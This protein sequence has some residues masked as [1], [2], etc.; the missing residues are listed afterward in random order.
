MKRIKFISILLT[1]ALISSLSEL[2]AQ[3]AINTDGSAPD[4]SA[5][6][7]VKSTDKGILIPRVTSNS[8]V[9]SP[10]A[11]LLIYNTTDKAFYYYDGTSWKIISNKS[12]QWTDAGSDIYF[13]TGG[14]AIG[15]TTADASA[16][17][18]V[19][20][21]N[22]GILIPRVTS[23]SN[24]TSPV[25]GLLIYNTTDKAFYYYDGSAWNAISNKSSQWTTTGSDIYYNTGGIAVGGT[26]VNASAAID[27]QST[28]KGIL[29]PRMANTSGITSPATGLMIYNTTSSAFYY[30]D[31]SAWKMINNQWTTSGS[32]I[33]Y[34]TGGVTIGGTTTDTNS[35][36][37]VQSTTKG[38]LIPRMTTTQMTG[39]AS[40]VAGLLVFNITNNNFYY[41]SG[42]GWVKITTGTAT[43]Q[44]TTNGSDIYYSTGGVA[45]GGSTPNSSA[46][47]DIQSTT[48]GI[49][50]PRMSE[51]ERTGISDPVK[52]LMV[53]QTSGTGGFYY[54]TGTVWNLVFSMVSGSS[55]P[56][57]Q[58]GT[59][60]TTVASNQVFFGNSS[61]S[62][63]SQSSNLTFKNDTLKVTGTFVNTG[64]ANINGGITEKVV[65]LSSGRTLTPNDHIVLCHSGISITLPSVSSQNKGQV[66]II[67]NISSSGIVTILPGDELNNIDGSD[68]ISLNPNVSIK[69]VSD[70]QYAWYILSAYNGAL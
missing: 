11:G 62:A 63:F 43:S 5:M 7:D 3:V 53:Y 25:A 34:N 20:S 31:G 36:L 27:V 61:G 15:G 33:Y 26:S 39:I 17:L 24:I 49:L 13:N 10:V 67:K 23:N 38:I 14:V 57:S 47:L 56:V 37:D 58:G 8:N 60:I 50:I 18:D 16:A 51:A 41:Y 19:Q 12:S 66:Y 55:I 2:K 40:P 42:S 48:K 6:L 68:T 54:Y 46:A 30:Y 32:N 29:I 35:I 28:T 45:I 9:T 64:N 70:G 44:W 4:A 65:N 69:I 52:G 59:G 22:K 1:I 21:T